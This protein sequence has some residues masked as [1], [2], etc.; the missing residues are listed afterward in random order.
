VTPARSPRRPRPSWPGTNGRLRRLV[1]AAPEVD[2]DEVD[3]DRGVADARLAGTGRRI[4]DVLERSSSGPP[5]GERRLPWA[6]RTI[7]PA[8]RSRCRSRTGRR[9]AAWPRRRSCCGTRRR[10]LHGAPFGW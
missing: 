5:T 10:E 1:D 3:A 6:W 8:A 2:V 9:H 7:R 4:R